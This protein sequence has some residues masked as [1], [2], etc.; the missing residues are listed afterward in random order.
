MWIWLRKNSLW[1]RAN[2]WLER[3]L[4]ELFSIANLREQL[5]W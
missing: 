5:S 1:R 3:Q 2:A 4:Y